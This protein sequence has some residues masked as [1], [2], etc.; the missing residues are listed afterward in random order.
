M[1]TTR[2][3]ILST[4][5]FGAGYIGLRALA[6]GIPAAVLMKGRKG[7]ADAAATCGNA[8]K[9][10]FFIMHTSGNGDPWN[11]NC[12][13]S[14][15]DVRITHPA[16]TT[17]LTGGGTFGPATNLS[18]GSV[19]T[20]AAQAWAN[21]PQTVLNRMTVWHLMT[22]TPVHPE[23]PDVLRLK[24]AT[25]PNEMLPSLLAKQLAPCLGTIQRQPISVGAASPS[26]GLSFNGAALPIIPPLALKSTLASLPGA[27]TNLQSLRDDTL[28][29]INTIY[30]GHATTAEAKYLDSV[31]A[32]Q[33]QIRN[34]N[35]NLLGQLDSLTNKTDP[36]LAQITAAL[37][38]VQMI[39]TPVIAIH[40]PF[41]GDNHFD[42]ALAT[43]ANQ[44]TTGVASIGTL[45]S[46]IDSMNLT[47]K[48]TFM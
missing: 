42:K 37:V 25:Q 16:A 9:A 38:L 2:R 18:L 7:F 19:Q 1:K 8:S 21:L 45:I 34:L 31:V 6:T 14:Y 33:Q 35:Q 27:L 39:V 22:N 5:L 44:T 40:I 20:V 28:S 46:T 11:A 12:P 13:G 3:N 24:G 29:R 48:V 15:T 30:K 26:E 41:G 32:S 17:P 43:E 36:V 23:Q 47:N 4:T 10:Q